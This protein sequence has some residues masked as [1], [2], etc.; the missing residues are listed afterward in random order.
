MKSLILCSLFYLKA[1][2][3][4]ASAVRK[5]DLS[6]APKFPIPVIQ[7]S[8]LEE[9]ELSTAEQLAFSLSSLGIVG[10]Q[11]IPDYS[12]ARRRAL[13]DLEIN[14]LGDS[15]AENYLEATMKF[16]EQ[17]GQS[18]FVE[19]RQGSMNYRAMRSLTLYARLSTT[20]HALFLLPSTRLLHLTLI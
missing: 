9:Q 12:E 13:S 14:C 4:V 5:S 10:V 7:F 2:N 8:A 16:G 3:V 15:I 18:P 11:G 19:S 17:L 1:I 20:V 6:S